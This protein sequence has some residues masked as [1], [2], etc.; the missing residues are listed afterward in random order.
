MKDPPWIY[1]DREPRY[2]PMARTAA[3]VLLIVLIS[4]PWFLGVV[5]LWWVLFGAVADLLTDGGGRHHG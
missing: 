4:I 1:G 2:S 5:W 3:I